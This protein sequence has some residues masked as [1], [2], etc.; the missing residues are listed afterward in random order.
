MIADPLVF[1]TGGFGRPQVPY[2][3][4]AYAFIS[5]QLVI[6]AAWMLSTRND[7]PGASILAGPLFIGS[8]LSI[9]LGVCLLPL[10]LIG[11]M[12]LIGILGFTPFVTG[13]V[14]LRNAIRAWRASEGARWRR[15]RWE[16]AAVLALVPLLCGIAVQVEADRSIGILLA[17]PDS[18]RALRMARW[19]GS[20]RADELVQA[21]DAEQNP[22]RKAGLARAYRQ[23]TGRD[24]EERLSILRD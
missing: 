24:A 5:L 19:F 4:F 6:F 21:W 9:A 22:A 15:F 18:P 1:R 7:A 8:A 20:S 11:L 13:F 17:D 12:F 23:L 2:P 3:A 16:T 14:Y 10:S